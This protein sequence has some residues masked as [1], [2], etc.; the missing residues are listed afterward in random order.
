MLNDFHDMFRYLFWQ[1][2]LKCFGIDFVSLFGTRS[3]SMLESRL[4]ALNI[5]IYIYIHTFSHFATCYYVDSNAI[6]E[7]VTECAVP[8]R[9]TGEKAKGQSNHEDKF[10]RAGGSGPTEIYVARVSMLAISFST[11]L[12]L[13]HI[14]LTC[15]TGAWSIRG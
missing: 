14:V 4:A 1:S 10:I 2:F 6:V 7:I 8:A 5:Y 12:A 9:L 13:F 11:C 15:L 3:A